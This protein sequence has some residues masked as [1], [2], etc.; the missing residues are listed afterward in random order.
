MNDRH[1]SG[2]GNQSRY[3]AASRAF[4]FPTTN[5]LLNGVMVVLGFLALGA[6]M[7]L[8]LVVL[9]VF[10]VSLF[11]LAGVVG[12]RLWWLRRKLGKRQQ[13]TTPRSGVIEG[14]YRVVDL[15]ERRRERR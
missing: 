3:G 6:A 7:L 4:T 10:L 5:P 1:R 14:E 15:E 9:A 12:L 8:G 11:V 13:G 2:H